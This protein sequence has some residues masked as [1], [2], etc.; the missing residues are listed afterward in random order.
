MRPFWQNKEQNA[1]LITT[2]AFLSTPRYSVLPTKPNATLPPARKGITTQH[3]R[4]L[5]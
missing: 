2:V 4:Y 5:F 3:N 1:V